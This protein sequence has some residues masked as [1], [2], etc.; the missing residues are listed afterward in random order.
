MFVHC[1]DKHWDPLTLG[2]SQ[3]ETG[4]VCPQ[5]SGLGSRACG[6]QNPLQLPPATF[7]P[8]Y[9]N[10]EKFYHVNVL[11]YISIS[12]SCF[13][14]KYRDKS[15]CGLTFFPKTLVCQG[16][17]VLLNHVKPRSETHLRKRTYT[18]FIINNA[19]I[20][21]CNV[22][23]TDTSWEPSFG[24]QRMSFWM[25]K[26]SLEKTWVISMW[27]GRCPMCSTPFLPSALLH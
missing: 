19:K 25:K 17:H 15:K 7:I 4:P 24:T 14:Y 3:W 1:R 23:K 18:C 5:K 10:N 22:F 27:K 26:A 12:I 21:C 6:D 2:S 11:D 16:L 13:L 8:G 9:D 20:K